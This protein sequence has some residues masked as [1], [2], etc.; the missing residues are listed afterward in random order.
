[1]RPNE[2]NSFEFMKFC[3][4]VIA[5]ESSGH[6]ARSALLMAGT[7]GNDQSTTIV[8]YRSH[9]FISED[10]S[11]HSKMKTDYMQAVSLLTIE[12]QLILRVEGSNKRLTQATAG[13]H[14]MIKKT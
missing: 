3:L 14:F 7:F 4:Q 11:V 5:I 1:M 6:N 13:A 9:R 2:L 12:L 10:T 8:F